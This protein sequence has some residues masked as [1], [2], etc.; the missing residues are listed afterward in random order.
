MNGYG[1]GVDTSAR[2]TL[3]LAVA[4][5]L[6]VSVYLLVGGWQD[7]QARLDRNVCLRTGPHP[8][9][10]ALWSDDGGRHWYELPGL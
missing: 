2:L 8:S 6:A 4:L 10:M 1:R 3:W 5:L 7:A 9:G